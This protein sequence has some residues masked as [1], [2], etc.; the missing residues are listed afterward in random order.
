MNSNPTAK[1][2]VQAIISLGLVA[3]GVYVLIT[4]DWGTKP[5]LVAAATGW[6]GLVVGY[7][8]K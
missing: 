4:A 6:I 7:W 5:A 1:L 2:L 8:L 3:A